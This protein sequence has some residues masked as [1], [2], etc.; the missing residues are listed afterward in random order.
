MVNVIH[1]YNKGGSVKVKL[2]VWENR[3]LSPN[4]F[5]LASYPAEP[6]TSGGLKPNMYKPRR[7]VID[8]LRQVYPPQL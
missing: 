1:A 7:V 6:A 3:Y 5:D 4:G 8:D 2:F